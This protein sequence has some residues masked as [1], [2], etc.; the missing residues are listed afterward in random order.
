M[1]P[2][3]VGQFGIKVLE[4]SGGR[5]FRAWGSVEVKD[6]H[7]EILKIESLKKIIE[8]AERRGK[9][10]VPLTYGHSSD[11]IGTVYSHEFREY[12]IGDG[13]KVP[14]VIIEGE[15]FKDYRIDDV[16]WEE[17]VKGII[18]GVSL[19]AIQYGPK[20]MIC[21]GD[22]C[23]HVL[24][25]LELLEWSLVKEPANPLSFI[26]DRS[27]KGIRSGVRKHYLE[28]GLDYECGPCN[29]AIANFMYIGY[30]KK[31]A[32]NITKYVL[33][34]FG[35]YESPLTSDGIAKS[36]PSQEGQEKVESMNDEE[37]KKMIA[38]EVAKAISPVTD[39]LK[40]EFDA[41]K[42]SLE[43]PPAGADELKAYTVPKKPDEGSKAPSG[44][45]GTKKE[46]VAEDLETL[47]K[48]LVDEIRKGNEADMTAS[49]AAGVKKALEDMHFVTSDA[50][51]SG[52]AGTKIAK[53]VGGSTPALT[54]PPV[55]TEGN[56]DF[57]KLW[58]DPQAFD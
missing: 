8:K 52:N 25:D 28:K 22:D 49:I 41:L 17:I 10:G 29:Q 31:D 36:V 45:A 35:D 1:A 46:V 5:R 43:A 34:V 48:E 56:T 44:T 2:E 18:K 20:K 14:G 3:G 42:K 15:V 54:P 55:G 16:V 38:E 30:T 6:R 39:S 53:G 19:G 40:K 57:Q 13:R 33:D 37:I 21:D 9:G 50:A 23:A 27:T 58:N 7:G 51:G 24:D 12:A 32:E 11:V 4:G 47:K 26:F